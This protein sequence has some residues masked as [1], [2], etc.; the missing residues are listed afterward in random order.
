VSGCSDAV[1]SKNSATDAG[2][3]RLRPFG[4]GTR[5]A[6]LTDPGLLISAERYSHRYTQLET[7]LNFRRMDQ[8]S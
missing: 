4:T 1:V 7:D 8:Q 5:I 6:S 3:L 2:A